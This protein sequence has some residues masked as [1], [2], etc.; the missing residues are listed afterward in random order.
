MATEPHR[1]NQAHD[2]HS[3]L[4]SSAQAYG[5]QRVVDSNGIRANLVLDPIVVCVRCQGTHTQRCGAGV[6]RSVIG[7]QELY[8]RWVGC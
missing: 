5:K 7:T 3:P 1:V 2:G 8:V 4:A 6:V